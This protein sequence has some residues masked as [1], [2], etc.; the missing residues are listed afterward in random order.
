[1][2]T[3]SRTKSGDYIIRSQIRGGTICTW[4]V[5]NKRAIFLLRDEGY[6]INVEEGLATQFPVELLMELIG[7]RYVST[8]GNHLPIR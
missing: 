2:P 1:M 5:D 3:L 8:K 4:Q 6:N 7:L